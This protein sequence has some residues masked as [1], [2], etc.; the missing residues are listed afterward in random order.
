MGRSVHPVHSESARTRTRAR[1]RVRSFGRL[2]FASLRFA[3]LDGFLRQVALTFNDLVYDENTPNRA[4]RSPPGDGESDG[5]RGRVGAASAA[6]PVAAPVA[7]PPLAEETQ[8][9]AAMV[10][11]PGGPP[12][13][14][15]LCPARQRSRQRTG[16][17]F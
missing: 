2:G 3:Q 4:T 7:R 8:T 5:P 15:D 13:A 12:A 9:R 10:A 14:A 11:S 1:A 16:Q 6:A 17:W